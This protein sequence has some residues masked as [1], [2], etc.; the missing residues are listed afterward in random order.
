MKKYVFTTK[1]S[2]DYTI[3][4]KSIHSAIALLKNAEGIESTE[5]INI[6]IN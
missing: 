5:I 6:S 1:N 4:A 2:F 3:Y